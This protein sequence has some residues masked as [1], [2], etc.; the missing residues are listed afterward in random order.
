MFCEKTSTRLICLIL[1]M[2]F[3]IRLL[4]DVLEIVGVRCH[5]FG[6]E[7]VNFVWLNYH[8]ISWWLV[9]T[10]NGNTVNMRRVI[11]VHFT[12]REKWYRRPS[13]ASNL[14]DFGIIITLLFL[15]ALL[16]HSFGKLCFWIINHA[17]I[18]QWWKWFSKWV[19][20]FLMGVGSPF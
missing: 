5:T 1:D 4:H 2:F 14:F 9:P 20:S 11:L 7:S 12:T 16:Y 10:V 13:E 6:R 3:E 19:F 18:L 8:G 17:R 15:I